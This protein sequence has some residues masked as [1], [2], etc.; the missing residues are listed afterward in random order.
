VARFP[1]DIV[2]SKAY[3]NFE[4]KLKLLKIILDTEKTIGLKGFNKQNKNKINFNQ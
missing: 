3:I 2:E 4:E 1:S